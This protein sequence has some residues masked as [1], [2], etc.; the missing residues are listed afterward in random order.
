MAVLISCA[1]NQK[2]RYAQQ[3]NATVQ[4]LAREKIKQNYPEAVKKLK[5]KANGINADLKIVEIPND[6]EWSIF[7]CSGS[8]WIGEKHRT[9]R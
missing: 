3:I 4:Q 8:E 9:W 7:G 5:K 1:Y 6:I 2:Q